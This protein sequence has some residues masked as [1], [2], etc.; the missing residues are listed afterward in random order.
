[1][2]LADGILHRLGESECDAV[3]AHELAHLCN[4]PLWI[5]AAAGS[6]STLLALGLASLGGGDGAL[7]VLAFQCC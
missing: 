2:V 4:D 5:S 1:M 6:A 3:I 7:H